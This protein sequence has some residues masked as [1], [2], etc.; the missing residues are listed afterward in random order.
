MDKYEPRNREHIK[1]HNPKKW[2][3]Y[4]WPCKL[5]YVNEEDL[6]REDSVFLTPEIVEE[7]CDCC[8]KDI[9]LQMLQLIK[10]FNP[11][12]S[13]DKK[14]LIKQMLEQNFYNDKK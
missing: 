1:V 6:M 7:K 2:G 13:S 14:V 5:S 8:K 12:L 3:Q 11:K 9:C 4:P 10:Q